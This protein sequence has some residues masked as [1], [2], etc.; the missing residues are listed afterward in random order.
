MIMSS[1]EFEA[2]IFKDLKLTIK[3]G[4]LINMGFT[5]FSIIQNS[6]LMERAGFCGDSLK[7]FVDHQS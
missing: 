2:P 5:V 3:I 7:L 6:V 1:V 4:E